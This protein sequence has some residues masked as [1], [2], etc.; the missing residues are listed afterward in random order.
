MASYYNVEGDEVEVKTPFLANALPFIGFLIAAGLV[1]R[2]SKDS[3]KS[4]L[5][6]LGVG[7]LCLLPKIILTKKALDIVKQEK[8]NIRSKVK[9][10]REDILVDEKQPIT[11]EKIYSVVEMIAE[12][13]GTLENLTPKKDFFLSV[14]DGFSQQQKGAAL[15]YLEIVLSMKK[16]ANEDEISEMM[17]KISDLE[18][19][20][21]KDVI[22]SINARLNEISDEV[23]STNDNPKSSVAA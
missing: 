9:D 10:E 15:D 21:G 11:S 22:D 5:W 18:T 14:F 6:G 13:N 17:N 8:E 19:Y 3:K 7:A 12:K 20:Y 16:D 2:N 1:Y 4:I 23:N